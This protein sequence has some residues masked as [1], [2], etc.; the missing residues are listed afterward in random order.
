[1]TR[2]IGSLAALVVVVGLV[3]GPAAAGRQT[4]KKAYLL[5]QVDVSNPEQYQKYAAAAPDV[6]AKYGGRYLARG[7]RSLTLE[8][9]PAKPR[10]VVIEFPSLEQAQAFY[11][12][13][14][15]VATRKLR[16]GAATAQFVVVEGL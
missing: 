11:D 2:I 12:S 14:E 10:V 3:G 16:E 4:A 1:M 8:G 15:Y 13:P 7:G 5:A 9:P 6:V